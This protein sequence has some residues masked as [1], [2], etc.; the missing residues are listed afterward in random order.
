LAFLSE[1][2]KS[3]TF[4]QAWSLGVEEKFYLIW[5]IIAFL[6]IRR[7][8][9][10]MLIGTLLFVVFSTF[11]FWPMTHVQHYASIM[12]GAL[13]AMI[14]HSP[15][16]FRV[17]ERL[18]ARPLALPVALLAL[19]GSWVVMCYAQ[20][21]ELSSVPLPLT[22]MATIMLP[23]AIAALFGWTLVRQLG[24]IRYLQFPI[25][26]Y[27][28]GLSYS[29]YITHAL[30]LL[31]LYAVVPGQLGTGPVWTLPIAVALATCAAVPLHHLVER[32]MIRLGRRTGGKRP[33]APGRQEAVLATT[34]APPHRGSS[35]WASPREAL[36][37]RPAS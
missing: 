21:L 25:L 30:A 32:P 23:C 16:G 18:F 22:Q 36:N 34:D 10:R 19:A 13:L 1:Y 15:R 6:L 12:A 2:T 28:G 26:R 7:S 8:R 4:G 24:S 11:W 33:P 31:A 29:I 14:L 35:N 27:L 20:G 5:P 17:L 37:S 9:E 3:S